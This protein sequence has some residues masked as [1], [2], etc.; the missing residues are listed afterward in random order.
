MTKLSRDIIPLTDAEIEARFDALGA[1][2]TVDDLT[3]TDESIE[4]FKAARADW[5]EPGRIERDEDGELV[6]ERCQAIA[7]TP[8]RTLYVV[9]FGAARAVSL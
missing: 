1:S 9:D 7:G 2:V 5:R 3:F 4:E 8:R 6:V